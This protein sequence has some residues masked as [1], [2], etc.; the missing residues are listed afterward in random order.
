MR[1]SRLVQTSIVLQAIVSAQGIAQ[2]PAPLLS[3][4]RVESRSQI[5]FANAS[6]V[7]ELRDGGVLV[8]DS[9]GTR[10]TL[11]DP[12]LW[13]AWGEVAVRAPSRKPGGCTR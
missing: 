3:I 2:D 10:V 1:A 4:G 12:L 9:A 5:G 6:H 7:V 8:L 11:L 13:I